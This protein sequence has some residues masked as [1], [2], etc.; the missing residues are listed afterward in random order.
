MGSKKI[1]LIFIGIPV[2]IVG[3]FCIYFMMTFYAPS[4]KPA[5]CFA[6][7]SIDSLESAAYVYDI[8]TNDFVGIRLAHTENPWGLYALNEKY[9]LAY[10]FGKENQEI[11]FQYKGLPVNVIIQKDYQLGYQISCY[12]EII[13]KYENLYIH[14]LYE[15]DDFRGDIDNQEDK[16]IA[17]KQASLFCEDLINSYMKYK[18]KVNEF[19]LEKIQ[20]GKGYDLSYFVEILSLI[21]VKTLFPSIKA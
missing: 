11:N 16:D 18:D 2:V 5:V 7:S 21:V 19:I 4:K 8:D 9:P 17:I 3:L 6:Y 14:S 15:A 20:I 10:D 1:K 13:L 12:F